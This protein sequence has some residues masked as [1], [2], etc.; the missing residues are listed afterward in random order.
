MIAGGEK[1]GIPRA[2]LIEEPYDSL[3]FVPT[4]LALTGKLRDDRSPLPVLWN[5]GF[6]RFPGRVVRELLP[7]PK[8]S[9]TIA[10]TGASSAP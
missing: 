2:T 10:N 1:T 6:R 9:P 4:L 5:K 3:S 7:E 8:P